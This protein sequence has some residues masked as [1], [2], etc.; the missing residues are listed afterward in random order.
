[1]G[2]TNWLIGALLGLLSLG[3]AAVGG[4]AG[5]IGLQP[6]GALDVDLHLSGCRRSFDGTASALAPDGTLLALAGWKTP[7]VELRRI[8]DGSVLHTLP[9]G[10]TIKSLVF[11]PDG[12]T[13][14][15]G[16]YQATQLW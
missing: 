11:S 14:A 6:C 15:V 3:L 13:L 12:R 4:L 8:D 7:E 16:T 9:V 5:P 10:T 1:M 2:K